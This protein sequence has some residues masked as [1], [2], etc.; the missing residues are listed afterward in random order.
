MEIFGLAIQAR[1]LISM[2][3]KL[4]EKAE[5]GMPGE[6]LT[7]AWRIPFVVFRFN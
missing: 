2:S 3:D 6:L 7:A 4:A 5:R 1:G